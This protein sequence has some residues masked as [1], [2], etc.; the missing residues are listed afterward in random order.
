MN[1]TV[2]EHLLSAECREVRYSG[3]PRVVGGQTSEQARAVR[4]G[5]CG[6]LIPSSSQV[7]R[8]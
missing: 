3:C 2:L 1:S 5:E 6:S 8:G 7:G 4:V